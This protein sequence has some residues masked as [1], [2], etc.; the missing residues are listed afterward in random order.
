[1]VRYN[2]EDV[3]DQMVLGESIFSP[4]GELLIASGYHLTE[5]YRLRLKQLGFQFVYISV[6]GVEGINPET[7]ISQH[8]QREMAATLNKTSQNIKNTLEIRQAGVRTVQK[9][10]RENKNELN[11]YI[12][13]SGMSTALERFIEEIL[14]QSSVIVNVSALQELNPEL[15]SHVINV[16][17]T[18]LC[19]GKKYKFSYEEMKQL[20]IGAMNYDLGLLA[21]PREVIEREGD[22]TEEE[23]HVFQQHTVYGYMMLSQCPAIPPTSS[24]VAL[25][26]HEREDGSGYPRGLKGNNNPPI[27]DLGR[28][29]IIHRFAEIVAVADTYDM[30]LSGRMQPDGE[31]KEVLQ[32]L[33]AM[34]EAGGAK[35]NAEIVK[36][37]VSIVPIFPVGARCR[38]IR[39]GS[40]QLLGLCGVVAQQNPDNLEKPKII[41]Y[42]TK[43]HEQIKPIIIDMSEHLE[44]VIEVIT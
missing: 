24:A 14:N 43:G 1:M 28:K 36:T 7:I 9:I 27:K 5:R 44:V 15:F 33:R 32:A 21:V 3:T 42:E 29:N 30:L 10:I 34:I 12:M 2:I 39:A 37:L 26:H 11:K 8:V 41:I 6:E 22:L 38:I 40:A 13:N 18:A 25:Q 17:I 16:T 4:S 35:L 23:K 20:G 31:K 19:I